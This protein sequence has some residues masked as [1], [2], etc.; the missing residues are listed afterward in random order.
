[1][2]RHYGVS[3]Q[4]STLLHTGRGRRTSLTLLLLTTKTTITQPISDLLLRG[5]VTLILLLPL[6]LLARALTT[7]GWRT[8]AARSLLARRKRA[9]EGLVFL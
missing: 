1:M 9:V 4:V 5:F 7:P 3:H 2:V 6:L 8:A